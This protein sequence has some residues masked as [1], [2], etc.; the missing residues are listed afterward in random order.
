MSS[1][2]LSSLRSSGSPLRVETTDKEHAVAHEALLVA[3]LTH[4]ARSAG[5][6]SALLELEDTVKKLI[7]SSNPNSQR[8]ASDLIN[9]AKEN[10]H[11]G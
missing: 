8:I 6:N 9:E 11:R 2:N 7:G 5:S 3:I 10:F 1:F 4:L